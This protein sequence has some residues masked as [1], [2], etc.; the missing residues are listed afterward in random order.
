[1]AMNQTLSLHRK[2]NVVMI[3]RLERIKTLQEIVKIKEN[4]AI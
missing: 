1:M 2:F 3:L 4:V